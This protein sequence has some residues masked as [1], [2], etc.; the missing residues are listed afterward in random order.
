[1]LG[2]VFVL[3]ATNLICTVAIWAALA[4]SGQLSRSGNE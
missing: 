2:L 4:R 3:V 1:M